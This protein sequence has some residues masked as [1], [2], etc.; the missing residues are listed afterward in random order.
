MFKK[1]TVSDEILAEIKE[2]KVEVTLL[3]G[4]RDAN[5]GAAKLEAEHKTLRR[6][7]TDLQIEYDREKEKWEREKREVT[8]MVGLQ[9][10]RGEFEAESAAREATLTVR[11]ENLQADKARFEEHVNFMERRFE[12]E[13]KATRKMMERFL[14]RMP[15]TKQLISVGNGS[16]AE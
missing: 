10:K 7:L 3:K 5:K 16:E 12:E 1:D 15:T 13:L 8:H 14:E 4:E 9:K 11:E 6:E 2:L